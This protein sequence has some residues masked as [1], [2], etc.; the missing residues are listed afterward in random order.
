M[1]QLVRA[2]RLYSPSNSIV[3]DEFRGK[4]GFWYYSGPGGIFRPINPYIF[5]FS[6]KFWGGTSWFGEN[7]PARI[8]LKFRQNSTTL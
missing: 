3:R 2:A 4:Y 5:G 7:S 8:I 6:I 1:D